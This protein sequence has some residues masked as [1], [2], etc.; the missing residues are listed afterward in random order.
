MPIKG[1]IDMLTTGIRTPI[2]IK[3]FGPDLDQIA[4]LGEHVESAQ[5]GAE[6]DERPH[7]RTADGAVWT[8]AAHHPHQT[9]RRGLADHLRT[10]SA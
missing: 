4:K 9:R 10:M 8:P 1:R 5:V 6:R 3:I 2:G 7:P